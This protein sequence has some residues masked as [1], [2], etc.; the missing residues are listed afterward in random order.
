MTNWLADALAIA[1]LYVAGTAS[2]QNGMMNGGM[3]VGGW[4]GGGRR[5]PLPAPLQSAR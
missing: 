1:P 4:M 5:E 3:G 2:A